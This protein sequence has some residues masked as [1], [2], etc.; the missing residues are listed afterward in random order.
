MEVA[1]YVALSS[2][3]ALTRQLDVVANNL[4]NA[5]TPAYKAERVLFAEFLNRQG[6]NGQKVSFVQDFGASRDA[7]QGALTNT[8][9]KLD[10]ALQGDGYLQVQTPLGVRYTRNGRFQ[11]DST[12]QI[13]NAQG[14]AVLGDG[15]APVIVP[16]DAKDITVTRDGTVTTNLGEAGRIAVAAFADERAL[17]PVSGGLY[18]TDA[19]PTKAEKTE[20]LQGMVE[21]SNVQPIIEMTR[22]MQISRN[23]GFAKDLGDGESDRARNAIDKLGKVA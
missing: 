11:L 18:V 6:G 19:K 12:G 7:K 9:N 17:S 15:N 2:Q 16:T 23:F 1:S 13:V 10:L 3:M 21:E 20:V 14:Y 4:A 8:G 5:S 22:M